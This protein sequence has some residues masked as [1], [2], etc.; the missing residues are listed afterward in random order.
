MIPLRRAAA[1]PIRNAIKAAL[2][3]SSVPGDKDTLRAL[4]LAQALANRP[5]LGRKVRVYEEDLHDCIAVFT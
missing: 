2:M 4:P 1:E 3:T 5:K